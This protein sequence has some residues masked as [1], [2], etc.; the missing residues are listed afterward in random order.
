[1]ERVPEGRQKIFAN[2]LH[3][4]SFAPAG[5]GFAFGANPRLTPWATICRLSEA[6][7]AD[8]PAQKGAGTPPL[9]G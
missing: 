2:H 3:E 7:N 6:E 9:P 1:M 5:A 8:G 4:L